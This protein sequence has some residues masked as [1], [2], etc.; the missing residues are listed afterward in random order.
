VTVL[1]VGHPEREELLRAID[2]S[3]TEPLEML[4]T[5]ENELTSPIDLLTRTFWLS[6]ECELKV[7]PDA[8]TILQILSFKASYEAQHGY[9]LLQGR[10]E[11]TFSG[12]ELTRLLFDPL[13][14]R[15]S[16]MLDVGFRDGKLSVHMRFREG[17]TD[18]AAKL[19]ARHLLEFKAIEAEI[20][21]LLSSP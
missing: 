2:Q 18:S 13:T 7:F 19:S 8:N 5:D 11:G 10:N 14:F 21:R 16:R 17:S 6:H 15:G 3:P 1:A 12:E 4:V 9:D 20:L